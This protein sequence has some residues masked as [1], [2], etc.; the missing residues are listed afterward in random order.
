MR[1][2]VERTGFLLVIRF[3]LKRIMSNKKPRAS[4]V[5]TLL[6]RWHLNG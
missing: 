1:L 6:N 3:G 2:A 4:H 5:I